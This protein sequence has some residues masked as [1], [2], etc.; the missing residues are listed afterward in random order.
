LSS[1]GAWENLSEWL[2]VPQEVLLKEFQHG[3]WGLFSFQQS[4]SWNPPAAS[5]R[6]EILPDSMPEPV[7]VT[8]VLELWWPPEAVMTHL[9]LVS[10]VEA[11]GRV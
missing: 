11:V 6:S 5:P 10:D 1:L 7:M 8:M 4:K 2:G 9:H 3:C